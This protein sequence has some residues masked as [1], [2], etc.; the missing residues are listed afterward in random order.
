MRIA[1]LGAGADVGRVICFALAQSPL[2]NAGDVLVLIG[3]QDGKSAFVVRG[4][5]E[6]FAEAFADKALQVIP[7]V[8][9]AD[10]WGD[11]VIVVA[12]APDPAHFTRIFHRERLAEDNCRLLLNLMPVLRANRNR[13]GWVII[14][15]NPNE[16]AVWLL[17]EAIESDRV[18]A[19]GALVDSWRFRSELARDLGIA[20]HR[21][22][23]WAG[24]EHGPNMLFFWSTA[25]VDG[26]PVD[27]YALHPLRCPD[28]AAFER[29]KADAFAVVERVLA[30]EGLDAAYR[31]LRPF[32][33]EVR[34]VVKSYLTH[35]S[36]AKTGG[37]AA[38]AVL[39]LLR[40]TQG[41]TPTILCAQCVS[42]YGTVGLPVAI[43][44][45]GVTPRPDLLS[46][47]EEAALRRVGATVRERLHRLR[48]AVTV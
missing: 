14:V 1:V 2:L 45:A 19:T 47:D 34:A 25:R 38:Q 32:P 15:T 44:R 33:V 46:P 29:A 6:D 22:C 20:P 17:T 35:T 40:A 8:D 16:L 39:T 11:A 42:P 18:L 41:A 4:M 43:S 21:V 24:G 37:I 3:R 5:A 23:A 27:P 10:A 12:S 31:A 9:P 28:R 48:A 13:I 7:S 26:V 30:A 36:G